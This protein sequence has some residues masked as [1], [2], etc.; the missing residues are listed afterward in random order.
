MRSSADDIL[1]AAAVLHALPMR[2]YTGH[3]TGEA[4]CA[5]LQ[6]ILGERLQHLST[7]R[8]FSI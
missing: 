5:L 6:P 8:S 1:A 3:C 7:G 2:Y 4:A